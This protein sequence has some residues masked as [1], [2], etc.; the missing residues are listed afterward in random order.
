MAAA[1]LEDALI[2]KK[3]APGLLLRSDNGSVDSGTL[4]EI[5]SFSIP[6][7]GS[8]ATFLAL[9]SALASDQSISICA[10]QDVS[11]WKSRKSTGNF[12]IIKEIR[13]LLRH[14]FCLFF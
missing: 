6:A 14:S 12:N 5:H 3:P 10:D 7:I 13:Y 2:R 8:T 11:H 9:L 4:E 1:A